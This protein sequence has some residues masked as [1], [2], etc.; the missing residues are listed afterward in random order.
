MSGEP[1]NSAT[2]LLRGRLWVVFVMVVLPLATCGVMLDAHKVMWYAVFPYRYYIEIK[3]DLMV[4]GEPVEATGVVQCDWEQDWASILGIPSHTGFRARGEVLAKRL[5]TGGAVVVLVEAPC[6]AHGKLYRSRPPESFWKE[7][8][9]LLVSQFDRLAV[10]TLLLDDAS[11]P[12][13]IEWSYS[14]EYF[15]DPRA[16]VHYV[17]GTYLP[18]W[19]ARPSDPRDEV[20]WLRVKGGASTVWSGFYARITPQEMWSETPAVVALLEPL[21]QPTELRGDNQLPSHPAFDITRGIVRT[22]HLKNGYWDYRPDARDPDGLL[23]L[24]ERKDII[25]RDTIFGTQSSLSIKGQRAHIAPPI[26]NSAVY[27][28]ESKSILDIGHTSVSVSADAVK[29][30]LPHKF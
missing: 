14:K 23:V 30:D 5:P 21:T 25:T 20:P 19:W 9:P 10:Q 7:T 11:E 1:P 4:D 24:Y 22:L 8:R 29:S 6:W 17:G 27:D 3:T 13:R 15:T 26:Y 2:G 12:T 18:K 16:R 28:P